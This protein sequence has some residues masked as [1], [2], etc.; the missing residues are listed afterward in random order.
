MTG[1]VFT[2]LL[3]SFLL[4]LSLGTVILDF[5]VRRIV[6]HSLMR[7]AGAYYNSKARL[8]AG[9]LAAAQPR[10]L[11][12]IAEA[13][14][15]S[16]DA[17]IVVRD[18]AGR[19][20]AQAT[21]PL[22]PPLASRTPAIGLLP[23]G[24]SGTSAVTTVDDPTIQ[25]QVP[26]GPYMASFVFSLE[27]VKA[28]LQL[29]RRDLLIASLIALAL[30]TFMAAFLAQRVA[31]RLSRI[32]RFAHRI[33]AGELSARVE[34]GRLD[35]ISEVAH[36]LDST[37]IRLEASFRALDGSRRELAVL[38]DSMQEAVLG[39]SASS[40]VTWSNS[41]MRALS[42]T[43]V[44]EGRPLVECIRD[45]EVLR[46]VEVALRDGELGR[47]RATN[48]VPGRAYGVSAAPMPGGGAVVV[49]HDV[50]EVERAERMRRDFVA[51]VSHELRT[52]L[53]SIT[54]Y[55][56][57]VLD[58]EALLSDQARE[59]LL[60]VLRNATRM[61]RL[62]ADL[63]ALASVESGDYRLHPK[64]V[65]AAL[66]LEDALDTLAGMA[67][68]S[69]I[70]LE[71]APAPRTPVLAD[72]DALNQVFGNLIE[73][74]M[75]YGRAGGR[76]RAGARETGEF[77]EFFVQ[78]FGAG[79]ASEHL[80]RIFERFY[81]VDKARSRDSGGTGLGLAIA[82]HIVQAHGGAIWAESELGN[83]AAFV[84]TLP[85]AVPAEQ[86]AEGIVKLL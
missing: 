30:A 38:L 37:A 50:T 42:P 59:F 85:R 7:E 5:S 53:T 57:T 72:L 48:F 52:P 15:A 33:A 4:V 10:M 13:Q 32:V 36:A 79:I 14:A 86:E 3:F 61:N 18:R 27:A 9:Q 74:A 63:L 83:G 40:Q 65:P 49:L 77:V 66:L 43:A 70:E 55:V 82:K 35:E 60:I 16:A 29:L 84:F 81:R 24:S 69:G 56:E 8:M 2:K 39:L 28:T 44:R 25:I 41:K 6:Q 54:G 47:G 11:P 22:L 64:P 34:E 67:M 20:L 1:R 51:N 75:K 78:D 62:T 45:P 12:V 26:A 21:A 68:D 19:V 31:R 80:Q 46:C 73:N 58:D 17:E 71:R 76:V 23:D